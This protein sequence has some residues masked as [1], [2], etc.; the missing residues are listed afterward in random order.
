MSRWTTVPEVLAGSAQVFDCG[1]FVFPEVTVSRC[2]SQRRTVPLANCEQSQA[3][4]S[5]GAD[6]SGALVILA[7]SGLRGGFV[8][9]GVI[10]YDG[11]LASCLMGEPLLCRG[12]RVRIQ[13]LRNKSSQQRLS[14][15]GPA[16]IHPLD[17][18]KI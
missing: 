3:S 2:S 8:C 18:I 7:D 10:T 14:L 16:V 17:L 1:Y 15:V 13:S 6:A 4:G 11:L 5:I 9:F 12:Q